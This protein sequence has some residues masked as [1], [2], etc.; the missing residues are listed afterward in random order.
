MN[1]TLIEN[2]RSTLKNS[3]I[4]FMIKHF[5]TFIRV[6]YVSQKLTENYLDKNQEFLCY[7][8]KLRKNIILKWI[9]K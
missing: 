3:N 2:F 6:T 4:I 8:I 7:N 9:Q 1:E 5:L